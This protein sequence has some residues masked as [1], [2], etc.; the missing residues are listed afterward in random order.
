MENIQ[1]PKKLFRKRKENPTNLQ[2]QNL[3]NEKEGI[4][5]DHGILKKVKPNY[6]WKHVIS[7]NLNHLNHK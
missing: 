7:N 6:D 3:S 2:N 4:I 5:S 1:T